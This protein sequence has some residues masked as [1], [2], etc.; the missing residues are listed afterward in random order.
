MMFKQAIFG[1]FAL[2]LFVSFA[3]AISYSES[4]SYS[5]GTTY[6]EKWVYREDVKG[7]YK[8]YVLTYTRTQPQVIY[9]GS[10]S[11]NNASEIS[12]TVGS[13]FNS[14]RSY[15]NDYSV[16]NGASSN[17]VIAQQALRTFQQDSKDYQTYKLAK[18]QQKYNRYSYSRSYSSGS[19]GYGRF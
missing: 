9:S 10:V 11:T 16:R 15:G 13:R 14:V 7:G 18:N 19:W 17:T 3:S 1:M 4:L 2:L 12:N 8:G 5:Q 6:V